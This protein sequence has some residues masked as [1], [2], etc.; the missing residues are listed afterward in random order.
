MANQVTSAAVEWLAV[1][2]GN[3]TEADIQSHIQTV[4]TSGDLNLDANDFPHL[5]QQTGDGTRR[6]I[7]IAICHAVIEVKKDLRNRADPCSTL[8]ISWLGT[9]SPAT[10]STAA[11]SSASSPMASNGSSTTSRR[12][13]PRGGRHADQRWGC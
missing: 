11:A 13:G 3:N 2:S 12:T 8:R 1:R 4:L 7:D 5:E 10:P 9:C 6:R